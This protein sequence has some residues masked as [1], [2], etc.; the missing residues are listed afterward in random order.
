[1]YPIRNIL[2]ASILFVATNSF[3]LAGNGAADIEWLDNISSGRSFIENKGQFSN[4]PEIREEILFGIMNPGEQILFTKKGVYYVHPYHEKIKSSKE[5][6]KEKRGRSEPENERKEEEG[7]NVITKYKVVS[8]NW[9]EANA[10]V[11]LI[12]EEQVSET[13]CFRQLDANEAIKSKGFRKLIYKNLYDGIDV[14][15]TFHKEIGF[16]YQFIVHPGADV[17]KINMLYSGS[18]PSLGDNG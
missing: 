1:M 11:Q 6:E 5:E 17:S 18:S 12:S 2:F 14:E 7:E 4:A 8:M 3:L 16:K 13:Y 15:Y 10:N 9:T